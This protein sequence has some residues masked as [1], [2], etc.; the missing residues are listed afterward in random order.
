MNEM[1]ERRKLT[2]LIGILVL[3]TWAERIQQEEERIHLSIPLWRKFTLPL[4][5]PI[6]RQP[7]K[8]F[9]PITRQPIKPFDPITR[10]PIKPI[11]TITRLAI[12]TFDPIT[13]QP[14]KPLDPI[15]REPI[16]ALD[17]ITREPIEELDPITR[18][19][20]EPL[21]APIQPLDNFEKTLFSKSIDN[22]G[23]RSTDAIG[24]HLLTSPQDL[25]I[26]SPGVSKDAAE[27]LNIS[28]TDQ[29]LSRQLPILQPFCD[30]SILPDCTQAANSRYRT[31][32]GSCNNLNNKLLGRSF[33]PF[34][35][36]MPALGDPCFP[37]EIPIGDPYYSQFNRTCMNFV[38]ALP[39]PKLDCSMGQRQQLNQNT[40]YID[41]S[42]IYGSDVHTSNSLRTFSGG[43]HFRGR[44]CQ[45]TT[46]SHLA[47]H[48]LYERA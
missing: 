2:L 37:I 20:I 27:R 33:T 43:R 25:K 7:I 47:P 31:M 48:N 32:D 22:V 12:K 40:H 36:M 34:E 39:T 6:T 9:D 45:P 38:W 46:G 44:S 16:E 10:R 13:R 35:R 1:L 19:H 28:I 17:P 5:D 42:Q 4:F 41:G 14:I 30:F 21:D 29:Q 24:P 3:L 23:V 15:T 18:Q 26:A 11:Y 8:T